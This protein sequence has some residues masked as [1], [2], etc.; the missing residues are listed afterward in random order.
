MSLKTILVNKAI[1]MNCYRVVTS[2][3]FL[4]NLT[5]NY[6]KQVATLSN[7]PLYNFIK[8]QKQEI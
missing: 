6:T 5:W 3:G 7:N 1:Q 2:R 8:T 4:H